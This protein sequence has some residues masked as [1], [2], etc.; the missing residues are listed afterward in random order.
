MASIQEV[1]YKTLN[2]YLSVVTLIE[3]LFCFHHLRN[4]LDL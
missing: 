2:P 4:V 1:F 3:A